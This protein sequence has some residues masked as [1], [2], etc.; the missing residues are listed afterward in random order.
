MQWV[1]Q[2]EHYNFTFQ[3]VQGEPQLFASIWSA[4]HSAISER[5]QWFKTI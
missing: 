5:P 1:R 3:E 2:L 4:R